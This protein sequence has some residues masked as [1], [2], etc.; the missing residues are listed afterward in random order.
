MVALSQRPRPLPRPFPLHSSCMNGPRAAHGR[1]GHVG[2]PGGCQDE[3]HVPGGWARPE[4]HAPRCCEGPRGRLLGHQ[5]RYSRRRYFLVSEGLMLRATS[6][7]FSR[8]LG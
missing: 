6:V 7:R 2:A 1:S 4:G 3:P 8:V 5:E